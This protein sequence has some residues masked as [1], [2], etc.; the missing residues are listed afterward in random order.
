VVLKLGSLAK[1][2]SGNSRANIARE[3]QSCGLLLLLGSNQASI[4][5]EEITIAP[6]GSSSKLREKSL[7]VKGFRSKSS[8]AMSHLLFET[9][10]RASDA[11]VITT[12]MI[13]VLTL[14]A[15]FRRPL[16]VGSVNE[17]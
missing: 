7:V 9:R 10:A 5:L 3:G 1:L 4:M 14:G 16:T 8:V 17:K 15:S 12:N 11:M 6:K 2:G 13:T